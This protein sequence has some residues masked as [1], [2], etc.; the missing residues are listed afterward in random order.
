MPKEEILK[1][2]V[3]HVRHHQPVKQ[4]EEGGHQGVRVHAPVGRE[5]VHIGHHVE[6]VAEFVVLEADR[7]LGVFVLSRVLGLPGA[8]EALKERGELRLPFGGEPALQDH[9]TLRAA[10]AFLRLGQGNFYVHAVGG[11]LELVPMY[12]VVHNVAHAVFLLRRELLEAL[13]G[14]ELAFA[15]GARHTAEGAGREAEG[16][17]RVLEGVELPLHADQQ[18]IVRLLLLVDGEELGL[19]IHSLERL[20]HGLQREAGG[21][22]AHQHAGALGALKVQGQVQREPGLQRLDH[23]ALAALLRADAPDARLIAL[24]GLRNAQ[25]ARKT[26]IVQQDAALQLGLGRKQ[27][28]LFRRVAVQELHRVD[29]GAV[30]ALELT[31]LAALGAD[32][33]LGLGPGELRLQLRDLHAAAAHQLLEQL[34][35]PVADSQQPEL[36]HFYNGHLSCSLSFPLQSQPPCPAFLPLWRAARPSGFPAS[37]PDLRPGPWPCR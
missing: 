13:L 33:A 5:R 3:A 27:L 34:L 36:F 37:L 22:G 14:V 20:A 16:P 2:A 21:D 19:L 29:E 1:D 17:Q 6:G 24:Q 32:K 4:D 26:R 31:E 23:R 30:L 10:H 15:R 28:R 12:R 18:H 35:L 25:R 11:E 9:D 7:D 8:A